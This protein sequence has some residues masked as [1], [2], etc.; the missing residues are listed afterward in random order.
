MAKKKTFESTLT[1]LEEIVR[2]LES[3][4][5]TLEESIKKFETGMTC[6]KFCLETLDKTEK[7][8]TLLIKDSQGD[9]VEEPFDHES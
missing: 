2:E 5:L 4:T 8:I 9:L 3:G 7:K 6:S 1:Q